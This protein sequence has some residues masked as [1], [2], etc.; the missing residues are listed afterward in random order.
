M[1]RPLVAARRPRSL[2]SQA[3]GRREGSLATRRATSPWLRSSGRGLAG[4]A[5]DC[6]QV[7]PSESPSAPVVMTGPL[8]VV[9]EEGPWLQQEPVQ[10]HSPTQQH[11]VAPPAASAGRQVTAVSPC[12]RHRSSP[13]TS[14]QRRRSGLLRLRWRGVP[15]AAIDARPVSHFPTDVGGRPVCS[16]SSGH[17]SKI[18]AHRQ[19]DPGGDHGHYQRQLDQEVD[20]IVEADGRG[21]KLPLAKR[22]DLEHRLGRDHAAPQGQHH[23]VNG[24]HQGERG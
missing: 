7:L 17:A 8:G 9:R 20:P 2:R 12:G 4:V 16:S 10:W 23:E 19:S 14:R 13:S 22:G 3:A 5:G 21:V 18:C 6:R 24:R 15:V 1:R 11:R